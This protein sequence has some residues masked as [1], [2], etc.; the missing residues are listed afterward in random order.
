M[1]DNDEFDQILDN[2]LSEYRDAEPLADLENRVLQRLQLQAE[3]RQKLWWQ[4]S[5]AALTAA[6]LVIAA[7]VGLRS[8]GK[9][10]PVV[11]K[12]APAS[13]SQSTA[14][15]RTA[16]KVTPANP[17]ILAQKHPRLTSELAPKQGPRADSEVATNEA[18]ARNTPQA[19][20][21]AAA[22][23]LPQFPAP[24]PLTREEH[25]LLALARTNPDALQNLTQSEGE[26]TIAPIE[27]EPLAGDG[28]DT[29]GEN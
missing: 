28:S 21:V 26:I 6:V 27:I 5:A 3:R 17:E 10:T 8:G 11:E 4:W 1:N 22:R 24:A 12:H 25:T 18:S 9:Q 16:P 15:M 19:A 7:W 20:G 23:V 29:Q 2:A 14:Q 13:D